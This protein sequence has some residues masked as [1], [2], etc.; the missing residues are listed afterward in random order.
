ML[1]HWSSVNGAVLLVKLSMRT[2]KFCFASFSLGRSP[3]FIF[4]FQDWSSSMNCVVMMRGVTPAC[5]LKRAEFFLKLYT[6]SCERWMLVRVSLWLWDK[7]ELRCSL[8]DIQFVF[9][10]TSKHL[11]FL[12]Y[13]FWN[14]SVLLLWW[15]CISTGVLWQTMPSKSIKSTPSLRSSTKV[16][17]QPSVKSDTQALVLN[18][19]VRY[20]HFTSR[21]TF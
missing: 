21:V 11:Y 9:L 17:P 14:L 13:I 18:G 2:W 5:R 15:T 20:N 12:K 6:W 7:S 4:S 16:H 1:P 8:S 10:C 19:N 3:C